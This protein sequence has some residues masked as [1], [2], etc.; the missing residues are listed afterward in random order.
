M[1]NHASADRL[2][3]TSKPLEEHEIAE[4]LEKHPDFFLRHKS[5]LTSLKISHE[6]Q[7]VV[8][9]TQIQLEQ[10]R[11]KVKHQKKQLES[12]VGNA[13]RNETIYKS[14]A[15]LN[16]VLSCAQT[17]AQV[18]S[19]LHQSLCEELGMLEANLVFI[20]D[21]TK[22]SLPELPQRSLLDKKLANTPYYFGRI[23]P[24]EQKILFNTENIGSVALIKIMNEQMVVVLAVA[25]PDAS[26]FTPS[27]DTSLLDYLKQYLEYHLP[28]ILRS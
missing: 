28:R 18:E 8:S 2:D 4:Y 6:N 16:F 7:G 19:A 24:H 21:D 15:S 3:E 10:Y 12:L 22:Q 27:M 1:T 26:H 23:S 17:L 25:S 9:L 20:N 5:L 13:K 11:E 14:Y